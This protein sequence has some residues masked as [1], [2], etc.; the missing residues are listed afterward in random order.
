MQQKLKAPLPSVSWQ[1]ANGSLLVLHE[2]QTR[3]RRYPATRLRLLSSADH[4]DVGDK[5]EL[6]APYGN[7]HIDVNAR[8]PIVLISG[9]VRPPPMI[10][11]L[12]RAIQDP[13]RHVVFVHG[14]RNSGMHAMR[15]RLRETAIVYANFDL[16]VFYDERLPQDAQGRDYDREG[17]VDVKAIKYSILLPDADCYICGP[18]PFM[19]MQHDALRNLRYP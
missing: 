19:Q 13:Q 18:I 8:T 12:K 11:M 14:A 7:F 2:R 10:S 6:A 15:D 1:A 4:V 5:V 17:L 3:K 16:V 9:G